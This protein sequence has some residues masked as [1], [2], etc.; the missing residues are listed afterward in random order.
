MI[1]HVFLL[2]SL[3]VASVAASTSAY[4]DSIIYTL[5]TSTCSNACVVPAGTVRLSDTSQGVVVDVQLASGMYFNPKTSE[6]PSFAFSA[7]PDFV[8]TISD[9]S[10]PDNSALSF[11]MVTP[12]INGKDGDF[13]YGIQCDNCDMIGPGLASELTFTVSGNKGGV[14]ITVWNFIPS[15]L[16]SSGT[17]TD[18]YFAVDI[19]QDGNTGL[20]YAEGP[21]VPVGSDETPAVPELSSFLLVG[22]GLT[23]FGGIVHHKLSRKK[24]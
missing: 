21:G 4:A 11:T 14:P 7:D 6:G 23:T 1:K 20:I 13:N 8:P 2:A 3:A 12:D 5:N 18:Y 19:N 15:Y 16:V 24:L 9:V 17:S 22:T 10:S